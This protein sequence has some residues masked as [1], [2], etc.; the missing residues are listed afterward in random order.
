[1]RQAF[2]AARSPITPR[3]AFALCEQVVKSHYE[4]F[5]VGTRLLPAHVRKHAYVLYAFC[6]A[7]DDAGDDSPGDRL[8]VL[9]QWEVDL[10]RCYGGTPRHPILCGL[11][12]TIRQFHLPIEPFLLLIEANRMD[13]R[14]HRYPTFADL[15]H[16]CCHSANPV[17]DL[18]LRLLGYTEAHRRELA[19]ATCTALQLT[20]FWQDIAEDLA[21]RNRIYIPQ[22]DLVAFG[23]TEADL[24]AGRVT[25][26]FQRLLAFEIDRTRELFRRGLTLI[27]MV[28][29]IARVDVALFS[30][31]GLKILDLIERRGY[32]VFHRRPRLS[33]CGKL[34]LFGSALW[35]AGLGSRA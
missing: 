26:Q 5:S 22:E 2:S 9:S 19:N 32:D 14:V 18:F 17:G 33:R 7:V 16:Y 31:G 29:G 28:K 13:Q 1:M 27:G 20:N 21:V 8:A 24:R 3:E 23:C 34:R 4:N 35:L 15:L 10:R 6:R 30:L 11:Q 12:Q 25:P